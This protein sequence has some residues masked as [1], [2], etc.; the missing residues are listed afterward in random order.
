[1]AT[2]EDKMCRCVKLWSVREKKW[3]EMTS[4]FLDQGTS[5]TQEQ[6]TKNGIIARGVHTYRGEEER[7][8]VQFHMLALRYLLGVQVNLSVKQLDIHLVVQ[9]PGPR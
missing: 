4:R 9:W 1:M 7:S 8:G 5:R 2:E 3:P 6:F